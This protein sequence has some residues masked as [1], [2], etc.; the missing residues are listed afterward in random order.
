[1]LTKFRSFLLTLLLS[2]MIGF[3]AFADDLEIYL[4]TVDPDVKYDPN[5]L[6]IMDTSG[7][8][9]N[10]D[11]T[12]NSRLKRVQDALRQ[13][14][15]NST[16]I[17]AGLMR[18]SNAG[19]PILFPIRPIDEP[20]APLFTVPISS[21]E[22][23]ATEVASNVS[24]SNNNLS[25]TNGS[26]TA[27]T[28]L[29]FSQ[30]SIPKGA[31][32][33]RASLRFTS[34]SANAVNSQM[35]IYAE[36]TGNAEAFASGSGNITSRSLTSQYIDWSDNNEFPAP[37][38]IFLSPDIS[39]VVQEVVDRSDWCGGN[40]LG[41]I[42]EGES[43]SALSSRQVL[44]YDEG[45]GQSPQLVIEFDDSTATGCIKQDRI[46]QINA[47]ADNAE[48]QSSGLQATGYYLDMG[49]S[50]N[51]FIGLRFPGLAIPSGANILDAYIEFTG[52]SEQTGA[53]AQMTIKAA[54]EDNPAD[55]SSYPNYLLRDKP[56]TS[57]GVVWNNITSWYLDG[58]YETPSLTTVVQEVVN[59][60]G[61]A[62][63]NSMMFILSNFGT[64]RRSAYTYNGQA[65]GA[66][67]LVVS[68]EADATPGTSATVRQSLISAV[69]EL[70]ADGTTPIVDTLYEAGLY[71]AGENVDYGLRRGDASTSTN[72]RKNTR[73][74]NRSSYVGDDPVR[75]TGCQEDNL[76]SDA[77]IEE[78]IPAGAKYISPIQ[79]VECQVN[80]HI[81]LLSDGN[82]VNNRSVNKVETLIGSLCAGSGDGKCGPELTAFF[83]QSNS[84]IDV[85]V[86]THTI[87]FAANQ[88]T[89]N[90]LNQLAVAGGGT[91][92]QANDSDS[93]LEVFNTILTTIKDDD[94]TFVAPGVAINQ[95]SR[96]THIDQLYYA[97]FKPSERAR[98]PGN[99]KRYRMNNGQ[100]VDAD[101]ASAIDPT[102]GFIS[103]DAR[104]YWS[105]ESDGNDV[106]AGGAVSKLTL[107]RDMF[108]FDGS[109]SEIF[110]ESNRISEDN[111]DITVEDLSLQA[112]ANNEAIR[113]ELLKWIRGVDVL[114]QN[115]NGD[116]TELN[117]MMGD[118]IHSA[119]VLVTY[120]DTES[121]VYVATNQGFLHSINPENGTENWSIIPSDLMGNL[122]K[123]YNNATTLNHIY[124][125]DGDMVLRRHDDKIW[126]YVGMR[127]GGNNYYVLDI[128]SPQNPKFV[129]KIDGGTGDFAN[130]GQTWSRPVLTEVNIGGTVKDVLVFGGGYDENQDFKQDRS[131][132][133]VGNSVFIVDADNGDLLW[134]ASNENAD[135]NLAEMKYS[136][137]AR[138]AVIDR[139]FD[140]KMDHM[141]VSDTGGQIFRFDVYN[142]KG[143]SELVK[144]ALLASIGGDDAVNNR[145]FYYAPDVSE[146]ALNDE[147]YFA[148]TIGSG[149]RAGP[150]N[151]QI[152]DY[153]V[154]IK[155][156]GAMQQDSDGFFVLP[157]TP[158]TVNDLYDATL[159]ELT[160]SDEGVRD[161]ANAA[162]ANKQ[163]WLLR[164]SANGEKVLSSPLM[165]NYQVFFTTYL[166]ATASQ[167]VCAP[168][169]GNSRAYLVNLFNAN[170]VGDLNNNNTNEHEDRYAEL[171]QTGIAPESKVL[172]DDES[173]EPI[174]CV[175][176]ECS[177]AAITRDEQGN[178]PVCATEFECLAQNIFGQFERV[179][180]ETW[181]TEVENQ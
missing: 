29:L 56:K 118:P 101:G 16:N 27:H 26:G 150:L 25:I 86:T 149:F 10:E 2:S 72:V 106:S 66:A 112:F 85:P 12:G 53:D 45:S 152:Q 128:T 99:L 9:S 173:V 113:V 163:G 159:H 179:H 69:D 92:Y 33:L 156:T 20:A 108:T 83:K 143:T 144:G 91:L 176:A 141:Y 155:D 89:N 87:G 140:G 136:I 17:N 8:M 168:P 63:D 73:V 54:A 171:N 125:L 126:L 44:A 178:L 55:F 21:A 148:V 172:F 170:A 175:G 74:S 52:A 5:V 95:Q 139:D 116:T 164:L 79:D 59:R 51:D 174:V 57:A 130:L 75:P 60:P 90:Y 111:T 147:S 28:G 119:P 82:P 70:R 120:S 145:R 110:T 133:A 19:G 48:E 161:I 23:D 18:F 160:S 1:M 131:P 32:I 158:Y 167:S 142:G 38:E 40:D 114:D 138:I 181:N 132:D 81:V 49:D 162:F 62:A 31:T 137:P 15:L 24:L 65:S 14:L 7:S 71:Y 77:C 94:S 124:G 107:S 100:V 135:L 153:F 6:F 103:S 105:T 64:D 67:K 109:S 129:F 122:Y 30:L 104:S 22:G 180:K 35:K 13:V 121:A 34:A 68:Y 154:M 36:D 98:W 177:D 166:P 146:I 42:I 78:F 11:G 102:T 88:D 117:P 96:L 169:T 46:Y 39:S 127:R 165:L 50:G 41:I 93:L 76:S 97:V 151:T 123:F 47:N 61:W 157:E 58:K 37:N 43:N 4:G 115:N 80:N 3:S 84:F 134:S